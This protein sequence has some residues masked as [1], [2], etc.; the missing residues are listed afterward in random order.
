MNKRGASGG[1]N[2]AT[3][4][5]AYLLFGV[6]FFIGILWWV[7]GVQGGASTLEDFYSQEIV[8]VIN[9][10]HVGDDIYVD[11]TPAAALGVKNEVLASDMFQV[12]NVRDSVIVKLSK[13]SGTRFNYFNR[14][15]VIM[16]PVAFASGTKTTNRLH[17]KIVE[18]QK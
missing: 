7:Y 16:E 6:I 12:D 3:W 5:L 1:D 4:Y 11:V 17:F 13:N 9:S 10:A 14:V 8:R 2:L 15:D 18:V